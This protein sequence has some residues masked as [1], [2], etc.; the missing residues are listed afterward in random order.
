MHAISISAA[1][2][3]NRIAIFYI[4]YQIE[5]INFS[6]FCKIPTNATVK[7][8]NRCFFMDMKFGGYEFFRTVSDS[9]LS[10][11][12]IS[13]TVNHKSHDNFSFI[14]SKSFFYGFEE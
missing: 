5:E 11:T 1:A 3:R 14:F 8:G 12:F 2:E 7:F 6:L 4:C 9:C 13:D 10:A